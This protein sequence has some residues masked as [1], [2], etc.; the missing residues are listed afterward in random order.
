MKII[1]TSKNPVLTEFGRHPH[2]VVV[3]VPDALAGFLIERGDAAAYETKA[4]APASE[5]EQTTAEPDDAE[6]KRGR[7]KKA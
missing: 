1:I 4:A 7:A 6:K 5:P 2:G 3:D